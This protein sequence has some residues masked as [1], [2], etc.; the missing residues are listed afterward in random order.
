MEEITMIKLVSKITF[1]L[2]CLSLLVAIGA[3]QGGTS[4][5]SGT[6]TD[7]T[8]AT[9]G[10]A[11]VRA[12]NEA[13]GVTV[14]Q[15]TTS[16]GVYSFASISPGTYTITVE[17]TGFKKNVRTKNVVQVDT[18]ANVDIVLEVGNVSETITVQADAVSV[19]TNTAT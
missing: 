10:G 7:S 13:T 16:G 2:I 6:V 5:L 1:L 18:P 17:Q 14:T 4:R 11:R 9:L 3:A 19:Q 15:V 12:T 8:G